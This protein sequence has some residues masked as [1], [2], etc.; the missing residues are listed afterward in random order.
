MAWIYEVNKR[1]FYH[2]E[3]FQFYALYAGA[4]GYKNNSEHECVSNKGPLPRGRYKIG[5]PFKHPHSGRYT[6]RLTP[7]ETNYM[8]GR[9]GFLIHGDNGR[10]TASNG[11]I[12][13]HPSYRQKIWESGDRELIIK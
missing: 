6:L 3:K 7:H 13:A 5:A 9:A 11:C 1:A 12:V 2:N 8:C 10:G 4:P